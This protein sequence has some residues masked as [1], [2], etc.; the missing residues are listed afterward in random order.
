M[1]EQEWLTSGDPKEMVRFLGQTESNRKFRLLACACVRHTPPLPTVVDAATTLELAERI[2]D[3][4]PQVDWNHDWLA[5]WERVSQLVEDATTATER[6]F[7]GMLITTLGED[8]HDEAYWV[9]SYLI[10][11]LAEVSGHPATDL[12]IRI[13]RDIF[14]N[15][16]RPVALD[17]VW[18]TATVVALAQGIYADR[19]FDRMPILADALQDA[20][21][22]SDDVLT[23][24]RGPG[25]HARGCWVVDLVLGK[26]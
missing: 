15:P 25:P 3:D 2:A 19:A 8:V 1:T 26:Q 24:C 4:D 22:D 10:E 9:V 12:P 13:V 23:H 21:C 5:E 16:F 6:R 11:W 17:P 7:T 18:R 20:G 14:G